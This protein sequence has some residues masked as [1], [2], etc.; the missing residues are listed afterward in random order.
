M[1]KSFKICDEAIARRLQKMLDIREEILRNVNDYHVSIQNGNDKTGKRC[2]TVSL[3]PIVDCKNCSKC[4]NNCYDIRNDCIYPDVIFTRARNSAI[5]KADPERYWY[6]VGQDIAAKNANELRIN[7][8]GDSDHE[9]MKF[10]RKLGERIPECEDLF[11]TKSY[12]DGNR[13]ISENIADYPNNFGFP[14]NVHMLYSRWIGMECPNP[15]GVPESHV[16]W[17]NGETTAPKFGA[18]FCKGNC[19]NCFEFKE[20]CP[21]LKQ[22]E[23]VLF[24]AH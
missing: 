16:L 24:R 4:K 6:E 7:V 1:A 20:G 21:T 5:H 19:T 10:I 17:S 11:F 3:I 9:D 8:G 14:S 13:F 23:S 18:Y 22:Y 2:Y 15:Y 12:D